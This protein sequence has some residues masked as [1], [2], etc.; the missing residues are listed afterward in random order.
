MSGGLCCAECGLFVGARG[1][2]GHVRLGLRGTKV[3]RKVVDVPTICTS[4]FNESFMSR[5]AV[6][7][8][9]VR[10]N[11]AGAAVSQWAAQ[12]LSAAGHEAEVLHVADFNLPFFA[13]ELPPRMGEPKAPESVEWNARLAAFDAA[14]VVT[15]EYNHSVPGALKNALDFLVPSTLG[16]KKAGVIGYSWGGAEFSRAHLAEVLATVGASVVEPQVGL[17]LASDW[18]EGAFAPGAEREAE[19]AS[20]I[21][22]LA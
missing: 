12:A 18:N 19:L 10:P 6:I 9:S 14:V 21:A 4:I 8:G 7:H 11:S 22:A 3:F 2:V 16:E 1:V 17:F 15:P 13:E 5:I 20:L